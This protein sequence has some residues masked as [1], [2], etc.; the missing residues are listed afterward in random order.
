VTAARHQA[1]LPSETRPDELAGLTALPREFYERDPR[2]VARE[3]IGKL[4]VRRLPHATRSSDSILL[5]GRI[6]ET[7]A[8]LGSDDP[9]AHAYR[10]PTARNAVLF[11][12]PGHAYVYFIYG[13][14]YCTNVSCQPEGDA[15]CCVHWSL[16]AAWSGWPRCGESL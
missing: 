11:G 3:L 15:C 5:A 2:E 12:P 10:G 4:L 1:V 9:A 16:C 14:H 6:V 7:E 13:N 8:Y